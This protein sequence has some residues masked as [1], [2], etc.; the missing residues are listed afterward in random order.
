[1]TSWASRLSAC[2]EVDSGGVVQALYPYRDDVVIATKGGVLR[3]GPNEWPPLGH[4]EYLRQA[5]KMSLR[6]PNVERIDLYQL[7][8]VDPLVPI[9]ESVGELG[10]LQQEGK[11]RHIG[12][13]EVS[14]P[15]IRAAQRVVDIVSVQ[16]MYSIA[17]RMADDVVDYAEQKTW[18]RPRSR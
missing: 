13:S 11:I 2:E 15:E 6:R 12:L 18:R 5:L 4:P 16:N 8:R 7:H 1:V 10:T 3:P 14:V 9:E 17:T